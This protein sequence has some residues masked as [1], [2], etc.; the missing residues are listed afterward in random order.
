[1]LLDELGGGTDPD[2]GAALGEALLEK[3]V[4]L[5]APTMVSTH[6]GRLKEFAF[7]NARAENASCAFDH[8]TLKP[9]YRLLLGTPGESGALVIAQRLGISDDV[10]RKARER[11]VRSD[12]DVQELMREVRDVR[13]DAERARTLAEAKL[14]EASNA[15]REIDALRGE[16]EERGELLEAE[17]QRG[18]EERVSDALRAL[19]LAC[20]LLPQI[21]K[22]SRE[23]METAL[24]LVRDE[25]GGASLSERRQK[26]LDSLHKGLFVFVPRY[27]KRCIVQKVDKQKRQIV[28]KIGGMNMRISFDEVTSYEAI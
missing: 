10:I 6:L 24:Q 17:A 19:D 27:K 23:S 16:L 12:E 4:E 1:M 13:T 26:F 9:L 22:G 15:T 5:R 2:E 3:L 21:P 25:L 14:A 20:D 28:V 7:R 8:E 11:L 18:I